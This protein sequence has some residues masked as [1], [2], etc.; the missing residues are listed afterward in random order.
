MSEETQFRWAILGTGDVARKFVLDLANAGARG[1]IVA[2]RNPANA[3][4][5]ARSLS[6]P[7][8]AL[9]YADAVMADVDAVYVATPPD[10]HEEHALL[11]IKAGKPVL[12]EKPFATNAA[13]ARRIVEAAAAAKVFCMEALWTRF[14]PFADA[15]SKAIAAEA[16]GELRSFEGRFMAANLPDATAGLFDAAR[17]GGALMHRGIYPLSLARHFLG[18]IEEVIPTARLGETGVD[19]ECVLTLRHASGALS[20][21]RASLRSGGAEG[22]TIAGTRGTL[23]LTGPIYR[24]TGAVLT[25]T[26]AAVAA[27]GQAG[28]RSLEAFRESTAGLQISRMV[29]GL[30][31]FRRRTVLPARVRGNGYHYQAEAVMNLVAAGH[32]EEPRMPLAQSMELMEILDEARRS[33]GMPV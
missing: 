21:I 33:W 23:H 13:A 18:P 20:T 11:A 24:P 25:P 7:E 8:V 19:E 17:G 2:S 1:R 3:H 14:Q 16:L 10:L 6:V 28:P 9:N 5:F 29:S 4:K 30:R 15:V 22:A 12:I 27:T 32:R 31:S 26:H